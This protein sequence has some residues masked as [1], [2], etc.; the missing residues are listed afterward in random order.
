V[1]G[2]LRAHRAIA[3][4]VF[5]IAGDRFLAG[6]GSERHAGESDRDDES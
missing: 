1:A 5:E 6:V 2:A 4:G 3:V